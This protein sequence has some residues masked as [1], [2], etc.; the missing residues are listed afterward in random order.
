VPGIS[1][2]A[3]IAFSLYLVHKSALHLVDLYLGRYLDGS[4]VVSII[5]FAAAVLG[6]GALLYGGVERPFL[7]LRDRL[8]APVATPQPTAIG[9][10]SAAGQAASPVLLASGG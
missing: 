8:L 3:A 1:A 2:I 4:P 9:H 5:V 6:A 7:K 10:S